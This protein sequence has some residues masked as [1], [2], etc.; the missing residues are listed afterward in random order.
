MR[1]GSVYWVDLSPGKDQSHSGMRPGLVIQ[2]DVLN[3]TKI[4]TVI[5]LCEIKSIHH[6][7][8]ICT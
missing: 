2:S 4:N 5:M 8:H 1:K 7:N 6:S 3:D